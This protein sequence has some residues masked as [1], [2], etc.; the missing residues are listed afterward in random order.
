MTGPAPFSILRRFSSQRPVSAASR[1]ELCGAAIGTEHPHLVKPEGGTVVC[2][3]PACALLFPGRPGARFKRVP[4]EV[5]EIQGGEDAWSGLAVPIGLAFFVRSSAEK[6]VVAFYPSP[7]GPTPA[8]VDPE[9]WRRLSDQVREVSRMEED[10]QALLV[11]RLDGA[12]DTFIVPI[13]R[14]FD[15]VGRLRVKWRGISGGE[16][17][18]SEIVGFFRKLREGGTHA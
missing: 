11:H 15:L 16:E 1:C 10:V 4:P 8:P 2:S 18:R 9:A 6:R 13:D 5:V 12:N 14:C 3:C 7:A 17:A